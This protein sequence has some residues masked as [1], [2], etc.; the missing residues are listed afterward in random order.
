MQH[1]F[2]ITIVFWEIIEQF[3]HGHKRYAFG[4]KLNDHWTLTNCIELKCFLKILIN[5]NVG[6][7]FTL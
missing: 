4:D 5:A 3:T 2:F 6:K 7:S 1:A